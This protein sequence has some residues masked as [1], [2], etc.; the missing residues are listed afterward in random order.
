MTIDHTE[1]L[2]AKSREAEVDRTHVEPTFDKKIIDGSLA[3]AKY[4]FFL[5]NM[6]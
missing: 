3:C 5:Q 4:F 1:H 6:Y 2:F